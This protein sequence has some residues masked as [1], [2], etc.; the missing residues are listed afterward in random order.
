MATYATN[1]MVK[2]SSEELEQMKKAITSKVAAQKVPTAAEKQIEDLKVQN[3]FLSSQN[4][5]LTERNVEL[6]RTVNDLRG[7]ISLEE[8]KKFVATKC[9]TLGV[10]SQPMNGMKSPL[11]CLSWM[12]SRV[13]RLEKT[14]EV[15]EL[16]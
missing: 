9:K 16:A 2:Y 5:M 13:W 6:Q 11:E 8:L 14:E 3:R 10:D 12:S 15:D 1:T 7:G 4:T